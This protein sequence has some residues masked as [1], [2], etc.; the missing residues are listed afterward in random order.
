VFS[1]AVHLE[2]AKHMVEQQMAAISQTLRIGAFGGLYPLL[3]TIA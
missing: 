2:C 3:T 1:D